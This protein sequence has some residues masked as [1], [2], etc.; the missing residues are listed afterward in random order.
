MRYLII[1]LLF[2]TIGCDNETVKIDNAIEECA[3]GYYLKNRSSFWRSVEDK[4]IESLLND[5]LIY[6][7]KKK[8]ISDKVPSGFR[9]EMSKK[10]QISK[11]EIVHLHYINIYDPAKI[12][13]NEVQRTDTK[14][15]SDFFRFRSDL[16]EESIKK[17]ELKDKKYLKG[18][19]KVFEKCENQRT[20]NPRTFMLKYGD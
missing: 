19:V 20:S 2:F 18:F 13:N 9:Q 3:T 8:A 17:M 11:I 4:K 1:L 16:L 5:S 12:S 6:Q 10:N 14:L 15:F 7:Q